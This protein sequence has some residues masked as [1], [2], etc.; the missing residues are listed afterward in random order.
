MAKMKKG[1]LE[2]VVRRDMPGYRLARKAKARKGT[3]RART[4]P[5]AAAGT[6]DLET[7][8]R[9]YAARSRPATGAASDVSARTAAARRAADGDNDDEIVAIEPESA[10]H[11]WDRAA[12]PKAV[13]VSARDKRIVGKQG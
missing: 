3:D 6:P 5:A 9:K 1:E 2:K 10:P 8:R 12:R 11:P 7:L 4:R 13:V